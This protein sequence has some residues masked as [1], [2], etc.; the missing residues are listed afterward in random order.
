MPAMLDFELADVFPIFGGTAPYGVPGQGGIISAGDRL[1]HTLADGT[2][3]NA[4]YAEFDEALEIWNTERKQ[5]SDLLSFRT[6]LAAEAVPRDQETTS[7]ELA[8]EYGV[9]Q[10]AGMPVDALV[11]GYGY[12]DYSRRTQLTWQA[13]R[14]MDRRAV[15]SVFNNV[16]SADVKLTTGLVL[17]RFFTPSAGEKNE[18]LTPIY[19]LFD[20]PTDGIVP[21]PYRGRTFTNSFTSYWP[22]GSTDLDSA[23][24]ED[25]IS[26]LISLGH[27]IDDGTQ[28][29]IAANPTE[30]EIIQSFKKGQE[31]NNS[32]TASHDFIPSKNAP[33][34][35]TDQTIVGELAPE[36]YG[37]IKIDGQYGYGWLATTSWI[38]AGYVAVFA[39]GGPGSEK[40]SIAFRE[41]E[42]ESYRGLI[43][44]PGNVNSGMPF[45]E[46]MFVRSC[47]V[48]VKNRGM[49][50]ALQVTAASTYTAP[51]YDEIPI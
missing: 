13:L 39:T 16:L 15:E 6:T 3:I 37:G 50:V 49:G 19:G 26:Q 46:T 18:N 32:Q 8:T 5:F 48:G 30:S 28:I 44:Q 7:F 38:P 22:T 45:S 17:R 25:A 21:M 43:M 51:D 47:G 35:L 41:H 40:N 31:N 23:D 42:I 1:I 36:E 11:Q 12:K 10:A 33:A 20:A 29:I 27:G 9:P 2:D 34:Y 14:K 4:I 24:I